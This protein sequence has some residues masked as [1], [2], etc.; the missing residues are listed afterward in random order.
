VFSSFNHLSQ[1]LVLLVGRL[2]CV[3]QNPTM[4]LSEVW[5][6]VASERVVPVFEFGVR[7]AWCHLTRTSVLLCHRVVELMFWAETSVELIFKISHEGSVA[8]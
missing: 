7:S 8:N 1:N 5:P 3:E 4:Q 6:E 2:N